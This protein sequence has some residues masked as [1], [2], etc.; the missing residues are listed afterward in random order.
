ML[1]ESFNALEVSY[2][3]N[4]HP[5]PSIDVSTIMFTHTSDKN[6]YEGMKIYF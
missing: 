2:Y 6:A 1:K 3:D 4:M 5:D